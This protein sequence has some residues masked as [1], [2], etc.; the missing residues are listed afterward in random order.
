M[1]QY[2][3][4]M[5]FVSRDAKQIERARIAAAAILQIAK[6]DIRVDY[7][8]DKSGAIDAISLECFCRGRWQPASAVDETF[9]LPPCRSIDA[10]VA[11]LSR[12]LENAT[13][14]ATNKAMRSRAQAQADAA[15]ET[16]LLNAM[17]WLKP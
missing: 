3:S 17:A 5:E 8:P 10:F 9:E 13:I 16:E 7:T 15:R 12:A 4:E 11:G 6:D 1:I 2:S 14:R